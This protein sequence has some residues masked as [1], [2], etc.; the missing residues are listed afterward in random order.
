MLVELCHL[1]GKNVNHLSIYFTVPLNADV[2]VSF[3]FVKLLRKV[4][5]KSSLLMVN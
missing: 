2:T 3:L 1:A 5:N 4:V